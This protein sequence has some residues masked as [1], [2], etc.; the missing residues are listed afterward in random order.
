MLEL[1][2]LV[3]P[4]LPPSR[5]G[6]NRGDARSVV[7]ELVGGEVWQQS[8]RSERCERLAGALAR[9]SRELADARK[10]IVVLKRENVAL[11]GRQTHLASGDSAGDA[12]GDAR[13]GLRSGLVAVRRGDG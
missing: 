5:W 10:E 4:R 13:D 7:S 6:K 12:P 8:G 9:L 2:T 1:A 11:R 3:I